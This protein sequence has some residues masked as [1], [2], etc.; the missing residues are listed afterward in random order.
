MRILR[1]SLFLFLCLPGTASADLVKSIDKLPA[2]VHP[3]NASLENTWN[4]TLEVLNE[5]GIETTLEDTGFHVITTAFAE[6]DPSR[7]RQLAGNARLFKH[8]RFTMKI[9]LEAV[10]EALTKMHVT[11]QIRQGKVIRK[12]Q[13]RILKSRGTFEKFLAFQV[14]HKAIGIQF[15]EIFEFRLGLHLVPSLKTDGYTLERVE[16]NSPAGEAGFKSGD[17]LLDIDGK[18]ISIGGGLFEVLL[19]VQTEKKMQWTVR[20]KGKERTIPLWI[21]RVPQ[22][23]ESLGMGLGWNEADRHFFVA[24][25]TA[26]SKARRAGLQ[27]GDILLKE[28]LIPLTSW[29]HYYRALAREKPGEPVRYEILRNH[30]ILEISV[31]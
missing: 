5:M 7:L 23:K 21:I 8:G 29:T 27:N 16:K 19:E 9:R 25:L 24:E 6:A 18:R 3:V 10:T 2:A 4:A 28:N 31:P 14:N 12:S 30:R 26:N 11:L 17:V 13:E 1:S 22:T 15:P 20:R